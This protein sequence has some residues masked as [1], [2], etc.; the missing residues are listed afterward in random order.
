M[1][2]TLKWGMLFT[3][4]MAFTS[5]ITVLTASDYDKK[6]DFSKLKSFAYYEKGIEHLELNNLDKPRMLDALETTM[7]KK[8]FTKTGR[9]DF[10]VNV[11]VLSSINARADWGYSG[12]GYQWDAV[13][14]SYQW[15]DSQF[16]PL[17]SSKEYQ[18]GTIIID[19]L[20]PETKAIMWHGVG[21]GFNFDDYE[22]REER[23]KL[24]VKQILSEYPPIY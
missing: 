19:F 2:H 15:R 22:N 11:V 7:V 12:G 10:L 13:S 17:N 18:S 3:I 9:P 1:K 23:I 20:N 4:V 5:C 21:S 8:G 24:A 6:I 16:G 14:S